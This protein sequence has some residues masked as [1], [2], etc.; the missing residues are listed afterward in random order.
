[1]NLSEAD[2]QRIRRELLEKVRRQLS[3]KMS[4]EMLED[5]VEGMLEELLADNPSE[6]QESFEVNRPFEPRV[7][8]FLLLRHIGLPLIVIV[9]LWAGVIMTNGLG[10][11]GISFG[12]SRHAWRMADRPIFEGLGFWFWVSVAAMLFFVYRYLLALWLARKGVP[13][14]AEVVGYWGWLSFPWGL[15]RFDFSYLG[16][17]YQKT[18]LGFSRHT[19]GKGNLPIVFDPARPYL[20]M[21]GR[22][23]FPADYNAGS[24]SGKRTGTRTVSRTIRTRRVFRRRSDD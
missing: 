20:W 12:G 3:A 10:H 9:F 14:V 15:M 1:M 2:I 17:T 8:R 21:K 24:Y 16:R 13:V 22:M 7:T 23:V 4:D 18:H 5:T 11:F 19:R 6:Q